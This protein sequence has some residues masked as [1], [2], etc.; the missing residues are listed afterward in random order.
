MIKMDVILLHPNPP[1]TSSMA[2]LPVATTNV[3]D[4]VSP[5]WPVLSTLGAYQRDTAHIGM[6]ETT[7]NKN[8][9][10]HRQLS[11]VGTH[12]GGS[13]PPRAFVCPI[14]EYV[15]IV[16]LGASAT[17]M[18]KLDRMQHFAEHLCL[19]YFIPLQKHACCCYRLIV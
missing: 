16:M 17:W 5:L 9:H 13:S 6:I 19:S 11:P 12:Q 7:G 15:S 4:L 18:S 3:P 10:I 1:R 14:A 8:G 2:T